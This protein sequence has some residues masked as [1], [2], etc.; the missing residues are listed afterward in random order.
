MQAGTI[1]H[2]RG[3]FGF[4][5]PDSGGEDVFCL[6]PLGGV[7]PSVGTRVVF[8]IVMDPKSKT[9]TRAENLQL[10]M[11]F[12]PGGAQ[13]GTIQHAKG[14]FGFIKPDSGGEDVFCLPPK[15]G[16]IPPAGTPVQ[17]EVIMDPKTGRPRAENLQIA[18]GMMGA[19][20]S[21]NVRSNPY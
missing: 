2:A 17:Y 9:G 19:R 6:P 7:L 12:L 13:T 4:I 21:M 3:N 16:E 1:Q 10:E 20:P 11:D 18:Y 15:D 5:K 14:N 8:D